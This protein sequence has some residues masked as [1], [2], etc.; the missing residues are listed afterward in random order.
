MN[1]DTILL[2]S[3]STGSKAKQYTI[4]AISDYP[5]LAVNQCPFGSVHPYGLFRYY[6]VSPFVREEAAQC[7]ELS[8]DQFVKLVMTSETFPKLV[9][10]VLKHSPHQTICREEVET[11]YKQLI[12]DYY[13]TVKG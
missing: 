13:N 11:S 8:K 7:K 6:I 3:E 4:P 5:S 2:L 12:E 9:E 1:S 10:Y